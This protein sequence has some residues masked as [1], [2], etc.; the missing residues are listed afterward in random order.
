VTYPVERTRTSKRE[1]LYNEPEHTANTEAPGLLTGIVDENGV[2]LAT[3]EYDELGR[4]ITTQHAGGVNRY[5]LAYGSNETVVTDPL[6]T[7]RTLRFTKIVN[8]L[9]LEGVD[10]PGG[11]GCTAATNR[12]Q[13]DRAGNVESRTDFNGTVTNYVSSGPYEYKRTEAVGTPNARTV[14]TVWDSKTHLPESVFE[15]N[16]MTAYTYSSKGLLETKTLQ[17]TNDPTG[18]RGRWVQLI[19]V[20]RTWRFRYNAAGQILSKTGPRTDINDTTT[21]AYDDA[22]GNLITITNAV[23]HVIRLSDYDAHGRVRKIVE[24][25]GVTTSL[26]YSPRGW[27]KVRTE[28]AAGTTRSTQFEYDDAGQLK[29]VIMPDAS[30]ITYQYDDAHRLIGISDGI[31]N[32]ISYVLDNLGNRIRETATDRSGK[33]ASLTSRTFDELNRLKSTNGVEQ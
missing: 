32:A 19:G 16:F 23:G 24:A 3:Y 18:A 30:V 26:A 13:Y 1:Y 4:G 11:A 5:S 25:N 12:L 22:T 6:G 15:P 31:G 33:L 20:P 14:S 7:F 2:R 21:Y 17:A 29:K 28:S 9:R 8:A 27:L 10:Q